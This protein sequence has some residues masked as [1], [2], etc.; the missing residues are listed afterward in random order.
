M[1]RSRKIAV[2]VAILL[3]TG[4]LFSAFVLP[5]IV[6][7]Q[8]EKQLAIAT[9]RK[10]TV[11]AV[12]I[13][14]L[15]WSVEVR[16]V[17]LSEKNDSAVFVSFSSLK[18][19]V[20]PASI[21]RMAP[22][23]AALKVT[24]P[25]VHLLR[26]APNSYNFTDILEKN[27]K[28]PEKKSDKPVRFSLNNI[29]IE[30]GR[31]E[32]DDNAL[33]RPARHYIE[34]LTLHIPFIS[35]ISYFADKYVDPKLSARVNGAPFSFA[36]RLKPFEKGLEANL[37]INLQRV[38]LP[39][40]AAYFPRELPV[41][42]RRGY[43]ST[44]L[45]IT[46]HLVR[47]G[48]P[49][50]NISGTAGV[51]DL[52]IHEIGGAPLFSL[53]TVTADIRRLALLA[54]RYE[55]D[56][57]SIS[58]PQLRLYGDKDGVWNLSRLTQ[59]KPAAAETV[60]VAEADKKTGK[61]VVYIH[62][63]QLADGTLFMK[64][65][66]PPGGSSA[67]LRKISFKLDNFA[68]QGEIPASYTLSLVT[69][70][71]ETA[72]AS[73][74]IAMEPFAVSARIAL[75]DI[76][77]E[78]SYPYLAAL[79][80][81]PIRGRADW[82][83]DLAYS[84]DKG[85]TIEQFM[86]R[87]KGVKAPLG[88]TDGATLPLLVAEGGSL[89]LKDKTVS[90]ARVTLSGGTVNL[91]R[92]LS[93]KLS[94]ALLFREK[95]LPAPTATTRKEG[96][97]PFSW[98][99]G[100]AAVNGLK[101]AFTDGTKEESPRFEF[102]SINASLSSITGPVL[103]AMP[104][105]L[106]VTY[107][108]KGSLAL[109]GRLKGSPVAF[110]GD[111]AI[112]SFPFI[113]FDSYLPEGVNVDL[114]DGKLDARL[115]LDLL[116][117][118]KALTGSFRG[119][120]GVRDFY[121]VDSEEEEDLLKWESLLF[122]KFSGTIGPFSLQMNGLSVNNYYA[123]VI[124]NKNGR[125]NLQDIYRPA[126][127]EQV[128]ATSAAAPAA[129]TEPLPQER[130]IRIDTVT[131]SEGTLDFSDHHLNRDFST[132]M[133]H[134]GGRI[135]GLSSAAGSAAD[136]DLRGNL[137]SHSPLKI[138][139][140]INPL[141]KDLFLDMEI[142][143]SEIELSPLTPYSGTY[144]GYSIDRGKLSL[145]LKYKVEQN[146]LT[147]ENRVFLDQFTFGERIESGKATSLPL[148]LGVALLKDRNGEIHLDLPLSGRT[149]SP[150]FSIWGL[151]GQVLKNLLVKAATSPLALL[152]ASIGG[153]ADFSSI[154]FASGTSRISG[155]EEEKLRSLVK[156]LTERP[157]IRLE[158]TG[159][160]DRDRDP[161]GFKNELLLKKMKN[162]KFLSLAKEKRESG[163]LSHEAMEIPPAEYSKWLK[164][165]YE[166]EKFP[167]PRTVV[168]ILKALPDD[169]M[170]KL[171]LANTSV[172]EQQLRG[173][174]RERAVTVMDFLLKEGKLPQDRLFEKSGDPFAPPAKDD[175]TGGRV[176]FGVV[177]K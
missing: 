101:L 58:A 174:A 133:L 20:S 140:K 100:T 99:I 154:A 135:S 46:H 150:R 98:K 141:A 157:G 93:G 78:A 91:S 102:G 116:L 76:V 161:E 10:C 81:E 106:D 71:K 54:K 69:D 109:S 151:V 13:N 144:L 80:T 119:E 19:R 175:K 44:A 152:Q 53:A 172:G 168:G 51:K 138:S 29:V 104:L 170:K 146:N 162:E 16:G 148:R 23:V 37:N 165:V 95:S 52:E 127:R 137:E 31:L 177:V 134:L 105:K 66:H 33:S 132:T 122:E 89:N 86:L 50:I 2:S 3:A 111:L 147:A 40:Y 27:A 41:Q 115:S 38:D 72:T 36:G 156:A 128:A 121:S 136:V 145:A 56:K 112:S 166:K 45:K 85:L 173:L 49:D 34:E 15:N 21:W 60:A 24:S 153:G 77:L 163:G 70:R 74:N 113:D 57:L 17:K 167:R 61:P 83:G 176:E 32:F 30:N 171:I 55:I 4:L 158:V 6:R 5:L 107:G 25:Y 28:K 114:L 42:I 79:L 142:A 9:D 155:S 169:E 87:L 39:Y 75:A 117:K 11:A 96:G 35:N 97:K 88:K 67:A 62:S 90:V 129:K 26:S 143:F 164:A 73:G 124:V 12:A 7:S 59:K 48:N 125:M 22:V 63:L 68:T 123:R 82:R 64:D 43:L 120:G 1:S 14:P 84:V 65:D 139:G 94:T 149:D 108:P 118:E 8:L 47:S 110:R 18:L 160:A 159:F 126:A 92:D 131:L 130:N 103:S